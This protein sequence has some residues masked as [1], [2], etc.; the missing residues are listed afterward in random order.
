MKNLTI[1]AVAIATAA[2]TA[3]SCGGSSKKESV[4]QEVATTISTHDS[5]LADAI[6]SGNIKHA[7]Q[8]ADSMALM[9]D[10]LT[11]AQ[12]VNV[13]ATF[14]GV[15]DGAMAEHQSRKALETM[16]KYV[17]VYDIALSINPKDMRKA[18]NSDRRY[19]F[20]SLASAYR[21]RLSDYAYTMSAEASATPVAD[22][23]AKAAVEETLPVEM[24]PAR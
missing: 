21:S 4:P 11:P 19:N 8:M 22:T 13:L 15:V 16:R 14:V 24:R 6:S 23:A 5:S 12:S 1:Y 7:S 10:D 2:V 20:D 3:V 9:V 18:I 17:D